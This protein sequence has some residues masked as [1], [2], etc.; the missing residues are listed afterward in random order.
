MTN[1]TGGKKYLATGVAEALVT[2][3]TAMSLNKSQ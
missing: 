2:I 3:L 1:A